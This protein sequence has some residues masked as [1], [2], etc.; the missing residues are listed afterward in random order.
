MI[1]ILGRHVS[2]LPPQ[3]YLWVCVSVDTVC[4]TLQA[5][6][7][8]IAGG[9]VNQGQSPQTGTDIMLAGIIAQLVCACVFIV[10]LGLVLY[11]GHKDIFRKR[12]VFLVSF[13]VTVST[14]MM[15][16]RGF[17][18]SVELAQ[19]WTGYLITHQPFIIGLDAVPMV[20]AMGTLAIFSPG[21]LLW[22]HRRAEALAAEKADQESQGSGSTVSSP[23]LASRDK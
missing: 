10:L 3:I 8:G 12:P 19:G 5:T 13:A 21:A 18:R 4:L 17:Y 6:G 9:A 1:Q 11:R 20:V 16:V 23:E 15:I 22:K 2:P 14:I 7:G